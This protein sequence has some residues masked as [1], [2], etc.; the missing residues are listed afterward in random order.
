MIKLVVDDFL[1]CDLINGKRIDS[2]MVREN[3]MMNLV[4][5][6]QKIFFIYC[7]QKEKR[8]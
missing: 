2:D 1:N 5:V 6:Y 3:R 8:G 7:E 4:V